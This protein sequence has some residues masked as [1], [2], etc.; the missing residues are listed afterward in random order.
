MVGKITCTMDDFQEDIKRE[1]DI[2]GK[3]KKLSLDPEIRVPEF[4]GE[5]S[6]PYSHRT[7][8]IG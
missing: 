6:Q 8:R 1:M 7:L 4:K 5:N 2:Y 3:L